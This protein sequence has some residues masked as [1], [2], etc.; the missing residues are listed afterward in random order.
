MIK[1]VFF[2]IFIISLGGQQPHVEYGQTVQVACL[3]EDFY[4]TPFSSWF[5]RV[6]CYGAPAASSPSQGDFTLLSGQSRIFRCGP[7]GEK[8]GILH[9]R[10]VEPASLEIHCAK[11]AIYFPV[12]IGGCVRCQIS[13][14]PPWPHPTITPEA[15]TWK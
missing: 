12:V 11:R 7:A 8:Y 14:P 1:H 9:S 2:L 6:G 4:I 10:E 15:S 5:W 3:G 13:E